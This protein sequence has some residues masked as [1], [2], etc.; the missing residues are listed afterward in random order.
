VS[1]LQLEPAESQFLRALTDRQVR[2]MVVGLSAALIEGAPVVTQDVDLWFEDI[3]DRN[4]D[5]AARTVGGGFSK[6]WQLAPRFLAGG[7]TDRFDVVLGCRGIGTFGDEYDRAPV[8]EISGAPVRVLPLERVIASKEAVNREKDR[9][10]LPAL[11]AT[12]LARQNP[13]E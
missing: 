1:E 8:R 7:G 13:M 10:V 9:M 2:F 11:K 12:L 5:A 4:I 3:E 6:G